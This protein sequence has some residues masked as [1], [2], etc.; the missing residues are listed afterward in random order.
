M[1]RESDYSDLR[2]SETRSD[3]V[4]PCTTNRKPR[5]QPFAPR[6]L[7]VAVGIEVQAQCVDWVRR[8]VTCEQ[9][10][11]RTNDSLAILCHGEIDR[12]FPERPSLLF[13]IRRPG[14]H[15]LESVNAIHYFA[16][17]G[18]VFGALAKQHAA[19][20]LRRSSPMSARSSRT[21]SPATRTTF[22]LPCRRD[23][24]NN[25]AFAISAPGC[26]NSAS[27]NSRLCVAAII[28]FF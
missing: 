22:S 17:A 9:V 28:C 14:G 12:N 25:A 19:N 10:G 11:S 27:M 6:G 20:H 26:A 15:F 5:L 18:P 24:R 2:T 21:F 1:P 23:R 8:A 13:C 3:V 7:V 16:D 4:L